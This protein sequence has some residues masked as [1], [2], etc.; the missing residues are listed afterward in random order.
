MPFAILHEEIALI[1]KTST[2][3]I[4]LLL[5]AAY[6][7]IRTLDRETLV[8]DLMLLRAIARGER[9]IYQNNGEWIAI[10]DH[11]KQCISCL[12]MDCTHCK[13]RKE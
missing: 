3:V 6:N 11:K 4:L 5:A 7:Y 10:K 9:I 12:C 1:L 2:A 8:T 13:F